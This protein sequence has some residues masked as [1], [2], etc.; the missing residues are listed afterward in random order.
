MKFRLT[1]SSWIIWW[2]LS[3]LVGKVRRKRRKRRE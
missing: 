2:R 1:P 3:L